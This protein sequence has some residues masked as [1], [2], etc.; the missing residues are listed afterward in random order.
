MRSSPALTLAISFRHFD[1]RLHV[2]IIHTLI[3]NKKQTAAGAAEED[4]GKK[5]S[6]VKPTIHDTQQDD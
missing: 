3:T 4:E 6:R 1:I 2:I 5:T